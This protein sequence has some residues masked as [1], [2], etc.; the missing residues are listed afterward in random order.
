MVAVKTSYT[1]TFSNQS[2]ND[3]DMQIIN[4]MYMLICTIHAIKNYVYWFH[5]TRW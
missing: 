4:E 5:A 1:V 2:E 3:I